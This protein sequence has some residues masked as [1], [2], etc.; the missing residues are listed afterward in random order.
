MTRKTA[1]PKAR[2]RTATTRRGAKAKPGAMR[3]TMKDSL[4]GQIQRPAAGR[5][6]G[7]G[8]PRLTRTIVLPTNVERA[9]VAVLQ[10]PPPTPPPHSSIRTVRGLGEVRSSRR[11]KR[12]RVSFAKIHDVLDIPNLVEIQRESFKWF[13]RDGIREVFSEISPIKDFTGNLE[14]HFAVGRK[15]RGGAQESENGDLT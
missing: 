4:R 12:S 14:L 5:T 9:P 10:A 11:G 2:T 6:T 15:R 13:L 3:L 7:R 1:S 8:R